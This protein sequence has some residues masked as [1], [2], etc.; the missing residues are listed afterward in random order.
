MLVDWLYQ[1]RLHP[2]QGSRMQLIQ[3]IVLISKLLG[4]LLDSQRYRRIGNVTN[5]TIQTDFT[6]I[7]TLCQLFVLDVLWTH[8][9]NLLWLI[10]HS[11]L[12]LK[13]LKIEYHIIQAWAASG[14]ATVVVMKTSRLWILI[15]VIGVRE[16]EFRIIIEYLVKI[17]I[18]LGFA[19][20]ALD[21][22]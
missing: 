9:S 14:F 22:I 17:M 8:L 6:L 7:L 20:D 19:R 21:R 13:F 12:L 5:V 16:V 3:E 15:R 11:Q 10:F 2:L 18:I 4:S 1:V